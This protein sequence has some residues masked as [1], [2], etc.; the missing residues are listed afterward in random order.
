[1]T[2]SLLFIA[3][4]HWEEN[5]SGEIWGWGSSDE[6]KGGSRL[7]PPSLEQGGPQQIRDLSKGALQ[8]CNY[9]Q[10]NR[11]DTNPRVQEE[12]RL[13]SYHQ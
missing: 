13:C 5:P 10:R 7:G 8:G 2:G 1:M 3:T 12:K 4:C 9:S 11:E 6:G